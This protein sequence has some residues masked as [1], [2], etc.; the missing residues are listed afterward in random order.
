MT[1]EQ[2]ARLIVDAYNTGKEDGQS[3][4]YETGYGEGYEQ[5][6]GDSDSE[7]SQRAF[8]NGYEKG[9]DRGF[10]AG[11]EEGQA[12]AKEQKIDEQLEELQESDACTCVQCTHPREYDSGYAA[13]FGNTDP[14]PEDE[15]WAYRVGYMDG[16]ADSEKSRDWPAEEEEEEEDDE[17]M[18]SSVVYD[19]G[20]NDGYEGDD[21]DEEMKED[22]VYM[23]GY[24]N[25]RGQRIA[26][27][28]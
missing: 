3:I 1:N 24:K 16:Q 27:M 28:N 21:V 26:A 22:R 20:W 13:G 18:P 2:I 8:D 5:G 12:N 17:Y 10:E 14:C 23:W 25:G 11:V 15:S 6:Y 9:F 19:I 4:G 7:G